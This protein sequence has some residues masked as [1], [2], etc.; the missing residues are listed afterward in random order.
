MLPRKNYDVEFLIL[1]NEAR[2]SFEVKRDGLATGTFAKAKSTA[3]A[4]A[5]RAAQFENR[6]GKT[7]VVCSINSDG[8]S[9][10]EWSA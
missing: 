10:V 7:A 2:R 9:V 6:E 4:L 3:I 5:M 8:K 1:W